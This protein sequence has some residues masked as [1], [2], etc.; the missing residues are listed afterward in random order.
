MRA[1]IAPL[2]IRPT[3]SRGG[4]VI[5][6]LRI[7]LA[8]FGGGGGGYVSPISTSFCGIFFL[9]SLIDAKI[10]C[11]ELRYWTIRTFFRVWSEATKLDRMLEPSD[12]TAPIEFYVLWVLCFGYV[13]NERGQKTDKF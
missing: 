11:G 3:T 8:F 12:F 5:E 7:T 9:S 2:L 10:W 1:S 13:A 4:L 6:C